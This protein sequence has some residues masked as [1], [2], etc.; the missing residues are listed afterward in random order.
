VINMEHEAF[1][2]GLA[3]ALADH[4]QATCYTLDE[5][6]SDTLYRTVQKE[7]HSGVPGAQPG[8]ASR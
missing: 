8:K 6:R 5:L 2:Q 1:D 3:H 4:L 7:I